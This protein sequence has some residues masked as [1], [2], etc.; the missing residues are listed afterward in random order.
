MNNIS[1]ARD[2][3][4]QPERTAMSWHRTAFSALVLALLTTRTGFSQEDTV[5]V[6]MGSLSTLICLTLVFISLQRQQLI[7]LDINLTHHK[8]MLSKLL[9]C[10][11]LGIN[12]LAVALH[13]LIISL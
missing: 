1:K 13:S 8:N 6:A 3:G 9:I 11:A 12:A 4:L 2:P 5:L 10:A 7:I